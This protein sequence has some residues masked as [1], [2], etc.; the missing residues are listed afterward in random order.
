MLH[1]QLI[2]IVFQVLVFLI[3]VFIKLIVFWVLVFIEVLLGLLG[4]LRNFHGDIVT[5]SV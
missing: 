4:R 5:T 1:I 3:L 2:L